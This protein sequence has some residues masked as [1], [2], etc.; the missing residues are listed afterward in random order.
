MPTTPGT[1]S[2]CV[3]EQHH[4]RC[5]SGSGCFGHQGCTQAD[6]P[7]AEGLFQAEPYC[8]MEFTGNLDKI[9]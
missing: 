5:R 4:G 9:D 6:E 2:G 3:Q 8:A 7:S 1:K